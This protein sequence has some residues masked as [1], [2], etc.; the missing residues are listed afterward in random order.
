VTV[1]DAF[2]NAVPPSTATISIALGN[3]PAGATLLGTTG[4]NASGGV[5]HFLDLAIRTSGQGYTLQASSPGLGTALSSAFDIGVGSSAALVFLTGPSNATAGAPI[6]PAVRVGVTDA[7]GNLVTS[8][9]DA[10]AIALS[11]NPGSAT[12]SGTTSASAISGIA[13]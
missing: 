8:A 7:Y 1:V 13:T 9:S 11:S 6:S 5:A 2:G 12:L 3:N 4:V 10:V